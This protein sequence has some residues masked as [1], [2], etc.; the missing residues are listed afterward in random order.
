MC[1][2]VAPESA[3]YNI[4]ARGA[5][6]KSFLAKWAPPTKPNGNILAY[7]LYYTTDM[8]D[9]PSR[10][11]FSVSPENKTVV[12]DLKS[13]TTYYIKILA[14]NKAGD[15]PTS[16][17]VAVKTQRGGKAERIIFC[18]FCYYF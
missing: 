6:D 12:Q 8:K 7:R 9:D 17:W 16:D 3:P 1:F 11:R 13:K 5:S 10:L 18:L 2:S 15:G 4:I 14:Y